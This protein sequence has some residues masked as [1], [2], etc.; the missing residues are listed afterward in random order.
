[1]AEYGGT[2]KYGAAAVF[3]ECD[4]A[5]ILI[6]S[7]VARRNLVNCQFIPTALASLNVKGGNSGV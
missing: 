6:A 2:R 7:E 1:M 5:N 3:P 4:D